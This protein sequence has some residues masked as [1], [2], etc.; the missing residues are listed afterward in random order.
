MDKD[1]STRLL[2]R[3]IDRVAGLLADGCSLET[4]SF[5]NRTLWYLADEAVS[6]AIELSH[7]DTSQLS[8]DQCQEYKQHKIDLIIELRYYK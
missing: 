8:Y 1:F 4:A 7:I 5:F 2:H 6:E 3:E